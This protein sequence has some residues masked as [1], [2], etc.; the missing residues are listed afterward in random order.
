MGLFAVCCCRS[1]SL[2]RFG[3]A[4]HKCVEFVSLTSLSKTLY[5]LSRSVMLGEIVFAY[6]Y[7][8]ECV[9]V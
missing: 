5:R 4:A 7:V 8:Y 2:E 9:Y 6:V 3:T 1:S